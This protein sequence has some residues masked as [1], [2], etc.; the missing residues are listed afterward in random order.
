MNEA[1]VV[2]YEDFGEFIFENL[3]GDLNHLK[4]LIETMSTILDKLLS[5]KPSQNVMNQ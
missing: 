5:P 4:P 2:G 3:D 1:K